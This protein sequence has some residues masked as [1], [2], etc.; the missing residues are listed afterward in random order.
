VTEAVPDRTRGASGLDGGMLLGTLVTLAG[1]LLPWFR[2]GAG[3]SWSYSGLEYAT[4][5]DGG[6]WTL[7]TF[8]WLLLALGAA[9]FARRRVAAA[10]TGVVAAVGALFT[11]LAVV[12]ASFATLGEQSALNPVAQVPFGIGLPVLAAGLGLLLAT[13]IRAVVRGGSRGRPRPGEHRLSPTPAPA[14]D[15]ERG[16]ARCRPWCPGAAPAVGRDRRPAGESRLSVAD[17]LGGWSCP[18]LATSHRRASLRPTQGGGC[19][20]SRWAVRC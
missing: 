18:T 10:M 16:A 9:P 17:M 11:S 3:Y 13:S 15:A 5:S 2:R 14:P 20:R 12:A 19:W 4:L 8:G 6:G 7:L 1:Y